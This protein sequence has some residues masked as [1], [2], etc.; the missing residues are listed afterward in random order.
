VF[1]GTVKAQLR[2]FSNIYEPEFF[3]AYSEY[4]EIPKGL[5]EA[6]AYNRT[7]LRHLD[8][9]ELES[10]IGLPQSFGVFGLVE[11]GNGYFS[12]TLSLVTELSGNEILAVK[13]S[14]S[15]QIL[16][17]A[18][19]ISS[20]PVSGW[21]GSEIAQRLI[22]VSE[23]PHENTAQNFALEVQL[24]EVISLLN[25]REFMSQLGYPTLRLNLNEIFGSNLDV[26]SAKRI[27]GW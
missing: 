8:E 11:D 3:A 27:L 9:T 24:Y 4:P 19:A 12:N 13:S 15:V 16:A 23:L 20:V 26:L 6:V 10:C 18:K 2:N 5:L 17:Y 1:F 25:N 22:H 7:N 14:T 21:N